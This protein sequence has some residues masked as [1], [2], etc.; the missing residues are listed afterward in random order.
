MMVQHGG[1]RKAHVVDQFDATDL[2][3]PF[4]VVLHDSVEVVLDG[5]G[6]IAQY[7]IPNLEGL[8]RVVAMTRLMHP[9]KL[10]GPDIKFLRKATCLKQ[11]ELAAKIDL[12]PETLS[13]V[14]AGK[15]PISPGSEKLLR[16]YV[17]KTAM[18][19]HAAKPGTAKADLAEAVDRLFDLLASVAA[20]AADDVLELHFHR[21]RCPHCS[22]QDEAANDCEPQADWEV[23][24]ATAA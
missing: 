17:L 12:L 22:G 20:H 4:K 19:L 9:R 3:A 10:S 21:A 16:L 8:L 18:K 1:E 15:Q 5:A 11:K 7:T 2:G 14:E 23:N 13:R 6:G 24:L